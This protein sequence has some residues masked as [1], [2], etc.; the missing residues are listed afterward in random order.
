MISFHK[1][2]EQEAEQVYLEK[3]KLLELEAGE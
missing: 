2:K 3:K 1:K